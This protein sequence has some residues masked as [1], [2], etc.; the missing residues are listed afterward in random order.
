MR[1][2]VRLALDLGAVRTGV[3]RCD[4]SATLASPMAVW[5][6]ATADELVRPL[7]LALEEDSVLE[8]IVGLPTDMRGDEA[9]AAKRVRDLVGE[10]ADLIP[11]AIFR[12]VDERLTTVAARRQLQSAGYTTR[13]DRKLI[14]AAA[15]T[16][17]LEDALEA[18]RRQGVPPGEVVSRTSGDENVEGVKP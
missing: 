1:S 4:A 18:E 8:V 11:E 7:R 6:A 3:A 16:V 9:M 13:T 10:L 12:L 14:D 5:P 15:A 2:G 17:L